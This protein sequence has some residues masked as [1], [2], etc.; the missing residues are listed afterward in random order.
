LGN[1]EKYSGRL[2][3][4]LEEMKKVIKD[5]QD[6][7][8]N[9]QTIA[10]Q[11][12]ILSRMLDLQHS[13]R[14]RDYSNNRISVTGRDVIRT[15]PE[16]VN[17]EASKIGQRIQQDIL[18]LPEEGYTKQFQKLIRAYYELLFEKST[19]TPQNNDK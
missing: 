12:R 5:F 7:N 16:A 8:I 1:E 2:D 10:R 14:K 15:S 18:R 6:E 3:R 4:T 9:R 13:L 19:T 11:Q 17:L